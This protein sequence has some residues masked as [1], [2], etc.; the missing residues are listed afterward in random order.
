MLPS[1]WGRQ[2]PS[3]SEKGGA[4][5]MSSIFEDFIDIHREVAEQALKDAIDNT[6]DELTGADDD[7]TDEDE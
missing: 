2:P 1:S 5:A 7:D 6:I 4:K 3:E